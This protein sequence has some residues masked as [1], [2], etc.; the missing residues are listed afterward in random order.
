[1]SVIDSGGGGEVRKSKAKREVEVGSER[2][3]KAASC[4]EAAK[5]KKKGKR[6]RVGEC[7]HKGAASLG[8]KKRSGLSGGECVSM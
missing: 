3:K 8:G 4:K 6:K 7:A 2:K 5:G 1:M